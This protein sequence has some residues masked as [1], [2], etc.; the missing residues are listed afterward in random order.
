MYVYIHTLTYLHT[1]IFI[2]PYT[3]IPSMHNVDVMYD[4][5]MYTNVVLLDYMLHTRHLDKVPLFFI[6]FHL[7]RDLF[8]QIFVNS[9]QKMN[10]GNPP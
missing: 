1:F 6:T 8:A 10:V 3:N 7:C 9:I 5:C 2:Q 4:M